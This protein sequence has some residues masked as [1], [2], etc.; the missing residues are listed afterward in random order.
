MFEKRQRVSQTIGGASEAYKRLKT[1]RMQNSTLM[2][3]LILKKVKA[4]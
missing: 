2:K 1:N 4:L 3:A